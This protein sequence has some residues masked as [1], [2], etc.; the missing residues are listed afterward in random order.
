MDPIYKHS[1][2]STF[3]GNPLIYSDRLG[4]DTVKNWQDA[5]TGDV[6]GSVTGNSTFW[7]TYNGTSWVNGGESSTLSEVVVSAKSKRPKLPSQN[8]NSEAGLPYGEITSVLLDQNKA[9]GKRINE[10]R[11]LFYNS[12]SRFHDMGEYGRMSRSHDGKLLKN[13]VGRVFLEALDKGFVVVDFATS[14]LGLTNGEFNIPVIGGITGPIISDL[15]NEVDGYLIEDLV[16]SYGFAG[17]SSYATSSAQKRNPLMGVFVNKEVMLEILN[18]GQV[19]L[20]TQNV[21]NTQGWYPREIQ[22]A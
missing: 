9:A 7:Y 16:N 21:I 2:Y 15:A 13:I 11:D 19:N 3:G 6:W 22:L 1:P 10:A 18:S 17:F 14:L 5:K 20:K 8:Q 12:K 4:L